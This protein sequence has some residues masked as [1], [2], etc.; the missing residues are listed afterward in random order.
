MNPIF[1]GVYNYDNFDINNRK[2]H[3]KNLLDLK[4]TNLI[5]YYFDTLTQNDEIL[6]K[7]SLLPYKSIKKEFPKTIS[8]SIQYD[9]KFTFKKINKKLVDSLKFSLISQEVGSKC[10]NT[11]NTHKLK[12]KLVD[13]KNS[14]YFIYK[15]QIY[16]IKKWKYK[17]HKLVIESPFITYETSSFKLI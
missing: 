6:L 11:D 17:H 10:F 9:I 13:S 1:N 7:N 12:Y 4:S 2:I 8:T 15:I 16:C 14:T 5:H 3:A